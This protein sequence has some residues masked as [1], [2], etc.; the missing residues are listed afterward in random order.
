MTAATVKRPFQID[1]RLSQRRPVRR[2]LTEALENLIGIPGLNEIYYASLNQP[3]D[4]PFADRVLAA[5]NVRYDAGEADLARIPATGPLVV[6][7]NHP[8]GGIEGVVL[9]SLL[10]RVRPDVKLLVNYLLACI[11]EFRDS[12]FFVDPFGGR[13]AAARNLSAMKSALRFVK[14]GGCLGVFPAGEV[15]HLTWRKRCVTDPAWSESVGR[16]VRQTGASVLPVFFDG[17][18]GA[19]FQ[20]AGLVHPRLR[21]ALLPRAMIDRKRKTMS[22]RVGSVISPARLARF[23]TDEEATTYLRVRTYILKGR[24]GAESDSRG[25][26]SAIEQ[27][28]HPI[29]HRQNADP[30]EAA[31]D[32]PAEIVAAQDPDAVAAEVAALD[33]SCLLCGI[34]AFQVY[35]ARA[36]E[37]PLGLREIGRLRELTFREVGEG[38]GRAIDLDRF[39]QTYLHLFLWN[40][41]RRHIAGAYRIGPTDEILARQG[42]D[43]LY[44]RTLF[45]YDR[46]LLDEIGPA[47]ELGRSFIQGEYQRSYAPLALLWKGIGQIALRQPRYRMLFGP[48]SISDEYASMTK[49]LLMTFLSSPAFDTRLRRLVRPTNPARRGRFRD[50][51]VQQLSTIVK[52]I[53]DVDELVT[54]IESDRRGMPVLLR[55]YLNLNAR[56]LGFNIDPDFGDVLDGLV[57]TDLTQVHRSILDRF[58]GREAAR[59][60]LAYHGVPA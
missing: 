45:R 21:T 20:L 52:S 32:P 10:R 16:I 54:E 28:Q 57:L 34:G 12:F 1:R 41:E 13:G 37:I 55:Q 49:E 24:E 53:D 31:G 51:D 7:A 5:M 35:L 3:A 56:L 29:L 44:T 15:S 9:A 17:Q 2:L 33:P 8:Y 59:G 23:A 27:D 19:V 38:T 22:F 60:F 4:R 58:M 25:A 48:V 11:P 40:R 18:N 14:Q 39:D 26:R 46:R 42:V 30:R 47:L 36:A 6:V 43:G 50:C